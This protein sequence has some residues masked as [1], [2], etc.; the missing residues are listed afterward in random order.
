MRKLLIIL[1]LFLS[2]T[3]H[4][5]TYYV[6]TTGSDA[7][8]GTL[9]QPWAT[10]QKAFETADAGDTVYF[11]GGVY[12]PIV[13]SHGN[14]ICYIHPEGG[15][16]HT[17][18]PAN[19]ICYF[20]YPGE[21]PILDCSLVHSPGVYPNNRYL[22]A[23]VMYDVH[24]IHFKGLTVRNVY[25]REAN[26]QVGGISGYPISNMIFENMTIHNI[27]GGGTYFYCG[28][29]AHYTP[30]NG[31]PLGGWGW[32]EFS[33]DDYIPYDSTYFINCDIYQVCDSFPANSGQDAG[34][35]ADGFKYIADDGGYVSFEGCRAWF[36]S[37]DGFDIP[38]YGL[39]KIHNCWSFHNVFPAFPTFE[40][41]GFKIAG[42]KT[43]TP[44]LNPYK[45]VTNNIAA[46]C[47]V[48]IYAMN[49]EE[50]EPKHRIYNN[51][52][53]KN[54]ASAYVRENIL[55]DTLDC[56]FRN[57]LSYA[58]TG[59]DAADR[60]YHVMGTNGYWESNNTWDYCINGS[61][62]RFCYTDTVT[63][64]D[65]DFAVA[66]DSTTI[67]AQ[68]TAARKADN[69]LPDLTVFKLA[70]TSDLIDAGIYPPAWDSVAIGL[71]SFTLDTVGQ[72]PDIGAFEYGLSSSDSS[73]KYITAYSFAAQTGVAVIDTAAKTVDIE[74]EYGTDVT[75]LVATFSLSEGATAAVGATPQV[76]GTTANNFTSPVTY[77]VTALD[78]TTQNWTVTV[79]VET[80][81]V[82]TVA[83]VATTSASYTAVTANVTG[84]IYSANGGTLTARGVCWSTSNSS[85]T[86][87]DRHTTYSPYVGSFTDVIRGLQGNTTYYVRAYGT[88]SEGGTS[89]GDAI[90]FT[91]Q[92]HNNATQAGKVLKYNG[93]TVIIK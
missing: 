46:W 8:A 85:P 60:Y 89:Y 34:N 78:A 21:I 29:G 31:I 13:P 61:L 1:F 55:R 17:G 57:N 70:S 56:V 67:M 32:G 72:Y 51:T 25:Q 64:T 91:T 45:I 22:G 80:E 33:P 23:L 3:V 14:N 12:Y 73:L 47:D 19:P 76:S 79:T 62:P 15:V 92:A 4:P 44:L 27:G 53:Y 63:V 39:L 16:G 90:S 58:P 48:G 74:V 9:A 49:T 68:L 81:P 84:V 82:P 87:S 75:T 69:S 37:D 66:L 38:I 6:S 30:D 86:T 77:V 52:L 65:D 54:I 5:A 35:L 7:Y 10:W 83:T 2:V 43:G 36:C 59:R 71:S 93:K 24:F 20:N 28:I 40:G 42:G 41:N 18:T 11:R 88:T 26:V 50:Y